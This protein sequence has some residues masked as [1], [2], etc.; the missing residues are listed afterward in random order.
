MLKNRNMQD[1]AFLQTETAPGCGEERRARRQKRWRTGSY[2]PQQLGMQ[3]CALFLTCALSFSSLLSPGL[4]LT[5]EAASPAFSR[6]EAEWALLRDNKL[7]WNEVE[8][9]V[10]EYNATVLQNRENFSKDERNIMDAA[11]VRNYLLEQADSADDAA[12]EAESSEG[13][14]I[15]AATQRAQA[16]S[17]R[18]QAADS[19]T[20]MN[21]ILLGYDQ[22]EASLVKSV[23]TQF[24][25]YYQAISDKTYA[26]KKADYLEK[27]YN[28][29]VNKQNVGTGTQ[30]ET[31]TAKENLDAAKA[32]LVTADAAISSAQ[33]NLIVLC[34]WQYDAQPEIGALPEADMAAVDAVNLETDTQK[35]LE[36]SYTLQIDRRRLENAKQIGSSMSLVQQEQQQLDNDTNQVKT[37]VK[38]AYD[39]LVSART[40]YNNTAASLELQRQNLETA[41]RQFALGTIS[42]MDL[43]AAENTVTELEGQE[44]SGR[45]AFLSAWVAYDAAVNGGLAGTGTGLA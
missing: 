21:T 1:K 34:G 7:E 37:A 25:Q 29:A 17:L 27:L 19:T 11:D 26:Q 38:T 39:S 35:A 40:A 43:A 41:K 32:A 30:L 14:S 4:S 16:N 5:A 24:I 44:I 28:S 10:H 3:T 15:T 18:Q 9:L 6:S 2:A 42:Q 36:T 12:D 8:G 22:T 45:Y 20:D 31:L 13:G 23:K 33:K